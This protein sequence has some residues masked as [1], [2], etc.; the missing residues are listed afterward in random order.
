MVRTKH[1]THVTGE[2]GSLQ[3]QPWIVH[4]AFCSC[5]KCAALPIEERGKSHSVRIRRASL[6]P[7]DFAKS[8]LYALEVK[9][10]EE[11]ALRIGVGYMAARPG[12]ITVAQLCAAYL[13]AGRGGKRN[14]QI[15]RLHLLPFFGAR[16]AADIKS[17]DFRRYQRERE[18]KASGDTIDR[19]WNVFRAV[20]NFAQTEERI[21]RNPIP[22]GAVERVGAGTSR[23]EF[24]EPEEWR[25]F[26]NAFTDFAAYRAFLARER[27]EGPVRM[28]NGRNYGSGKR[29][30]ESEASRIRF[31]RMREL[32]PYF[33]ALLFG[34]ARLHEMTRMCWRDVDLRRGIVTLYQEKTEKEKI[35][36]IAA[37]WRAELE[38][39]QRGLPAAFVYARANGHVLTTQEVEKTFAFAVRLAGIEKDLI[40][41]SIRHTALSWLATAGF[42]KVHRDE[43]AGHARRE[44]GDGYAHLTKGSLMPA[45]EALARI[46]REGFTSEERRA[47]E[48]SNG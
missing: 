19:E 14:E 43:I 23:K 4:P 47:E 33:R 40:P 1:A 2:I 29:N 5:R 9:A 18:G 27:E 35:L 36:P 3:I 24:F 34:C 26:M 30:P 28:V 31:E 32:G 48:A 22:R 39:R 7:K 46:E 13:E 42:S 25:A 11:E 15:I 10:K 16:I 6:H 12:E 41:H 45:V 44:V 17:S 20:L 38:S 37:P 21:E 8:V